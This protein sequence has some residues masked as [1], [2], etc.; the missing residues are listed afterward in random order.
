MKRTV[1][2]S[3]TED[4]T[5]LFHKKTRLNTTVHDLPADVIR[6]T[7]EDLTTMQTLKLCK[8]D[9]HFYSAIYDNV[10]FWKV[11][12]EKLGLLVSEDTTAAELR[13]RI[14]AVER[15]NKI[16]EIPFRALGKSNV[17]RHPEH[18]EL[19]SKWFEGLRQEYAGKHTQL[20]QKYG[21]EI[22]SPDEFNQ[23]ICSI[24]L[25]AH[26]YD[27]ITLGG[28]L[29]SIRRKNDHL[30]ICHARLS[31]C[32]V[33]ARFPRTIYATYI[34]N[35]DFSFFG[36][37]YNFYKMPVDRSLIAKHYD[38]NYLNFIFLDDTGRQWLIA[39]DAPIREINGVPM[40]V[41]LIESN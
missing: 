2:S 33:Q 13:S 41:K 24:E 28:R 35:S 23:T 8:T 37:L 25:I 14:L 3:S 20:Y 31:I 9:K 27:F 5:A 4:I 30:V 22:E 32:L 7:A 40:K 26:E 6:K 19:L 16:I 21:H 1:P 38:R 11:K 15:G 39:D 10:P 12:A 34:T 36:R 18:E 29:Y 17:L